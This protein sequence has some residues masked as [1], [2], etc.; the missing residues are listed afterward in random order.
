MK[1]LSN[2]LLL[3]M[4]TL[5]ISSNSNTQFFKELGERVKER[6]KSRLERKVE[7]KTDQAMDSL[8]MKTERAF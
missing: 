2:D 6:S 8:F 3:A 1:G 5:V 7:G 4:I